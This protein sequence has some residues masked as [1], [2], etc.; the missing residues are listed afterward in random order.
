MRR[1]GAGLP[2]IDAA[3]EYALKVGDVVGLRRSVRPGL[4]GQ[5]TTAPG[6][7]TTQLGEPVHRR[8]GSLMR[9]FCLLRGPD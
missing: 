5:R 7:L 6:V 2:A 4:L 1:V 3:V 8:C 9:R